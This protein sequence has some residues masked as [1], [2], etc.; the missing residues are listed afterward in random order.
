MKAYS[1]AVSALLATVTSGPFAAAFTPSSFTRRVR[2]FSNTN[3]FANVPIASDSRYLSQLN[4]SSAGF[5]GMDEED[6]DDD[7]T[8]VTR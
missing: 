8:L 3:N 1:F 7:G 5:I 2:L 6:E 4:L